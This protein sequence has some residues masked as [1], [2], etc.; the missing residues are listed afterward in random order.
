MNKI[1]FL[2]GVPASGK[3]TIARMLAENSPKSIHIQ[4]DHLREMM[5]SGLHLP[6]G[7]KWSEE[8]TRQFQW[9]RSSAGYMAN[10]YASNGVDA[11]I[12]DVCV[13]Q[14]FADQ[15]A[16][17]FKNPAVRRVLLLPSLES[18][19]KRLIERAGPYDSHMISVMPLLYEYLV[20]MPKDG[21]IVLDSSAWSVEQTFQEV[22]KRVD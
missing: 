14:F 21:W 18:I 4:V 11:F 17:L 16:E 6:G 10:L 13:P 19:N 2:T 1:V 5:V 20:P 15:Y 3:T 8:A 22:L 12:D 9:G 7:G